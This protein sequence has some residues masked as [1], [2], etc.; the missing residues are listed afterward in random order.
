MTDQTSMW[1]LPAWA[2]NILRLNRASFAA[3]GESPMT[4]GT[5]LFDA[6]DDGPGSFEDLG[7][8]NGERYCRAERGPCC[9]GGTRR[10]GA[11]RVAATGGPSRC[12]LVASLSRNVAG[13]CGL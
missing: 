12:R 10:A 9:G 4:D 6:M 8:E 11:L 13:R 2:V 3:A 7:H 5:D 1:T